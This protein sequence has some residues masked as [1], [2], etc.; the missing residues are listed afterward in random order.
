MGIETT[1]KNALGGPPK[2]RVLLAEDH[3]LVRAGLCALLES[4]SG[5]EVVAQ[6]SDGREAIAL[7]AKH[8]PHIAV[9]DITMANMNGLEAAARIAR[10]FPNVRVIILS[11]HSSE[12]YVLQALRLS[13]VGYLLKDSGL[14][15]LELA[16]RT[17]ASGETY[18]SPAVS[19]HVAEYVRRVGTDDEVSESPMETLTPRQREILQLV[20]EGHTTQQ[21]AQKLVISVKTVESHRQQLMDRLNIRDVAGLVRYAIRVGLAAP[22]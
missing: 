17:V 14:T 11:M 22:E 15:E 8:Q 5:I 13:V 12:E 16:L 9:L 21:I 20:A 18:I 4:M 10:D 7:I 19:K 2:I 3:A 6:A 1:T